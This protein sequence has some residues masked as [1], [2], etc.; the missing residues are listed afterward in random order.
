MNVEQVNGTRENMSALEEKVEKLLLYCV[1]DSPRLRQHYQTDLQALLGSACREELAVRIDRVLLDLGI[2]DHLLGY[3]YLQ[4]AIMRVVREPEL[5]YCLT[6]G[7]YPGVARQFGTTGNL[8]ERAIRHAV[9]SGWN[10]CEESM[11]RLYFGG[12]IRPG[13]Q[14]PT[15]AEFIARVANIVRN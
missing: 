15:N 3:R 6:G 5:A 14:R 10:R 1:A 8:V 13:R 4:A 2:P 11:R 7:L 9:E 12:K